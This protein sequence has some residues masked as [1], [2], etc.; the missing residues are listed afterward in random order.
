MIYRVRGYD[1]RR[2]ARLLPYWSRTA[3]TDARDRINDYCVRVS[4]GRAHGPG[5]ALEL[6]QY[7]YHV[8]VLT[9]RGWRHDIDLD[10]DPY[11]TGEFFPSDLW[12]KRRRDA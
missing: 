2:T 12:G 9:R 7:P 4:F 11:G 10:D 6:P 8:E 3:A 5:G 1:G